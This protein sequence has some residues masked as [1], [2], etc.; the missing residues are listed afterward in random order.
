MADTKD[1]KKKKTKKVNTEKAGAKAE[2]VQNSEFA[3]NEKPHQRR[4]SHFHTQTF[5]TG[6]ETWSS[7]RIRW[8]RSTNF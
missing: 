2:P 4:K 1:V 3:E 5:R 7:T 6:S 8:K